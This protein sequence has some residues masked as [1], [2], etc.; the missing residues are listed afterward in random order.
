MKR[1][2]F[3]T[4]LGGAVTWP[5]GARAQQSAMPVGAWPQGAA[6]VARARRRNHRCTAR[7]H[8]AAGGATTGSG[9]AVRVNRL[10]AGTG[11]PQ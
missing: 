10:R 7:Y 3:I 8:H 5:L 9:L 4:L 2:R 1:R 6:V 11:R